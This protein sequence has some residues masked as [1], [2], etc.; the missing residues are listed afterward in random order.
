MAKQAYSS[1]SNITYYYWRPT[2][3]L[4]Q[5]R[6]ISFPNYSSSTPHVHFILLHPRHTQ[7]QKY[8]KGY[9]L[10]SGFELWK[11]NWGVS[12]TAETKGLRG[13]NGMD[14]GIK[15]SIPPVNSNPGWDFLVQW[16]N[17]SIPPFS[18][19]NVLHHNYLPCSNS[20]IHQYSLNTLHVTDLVL[21]LSKKSPI[22]L[23]LVHGCIQQTGVQWTSSWNYVV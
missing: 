19:F 2:Q 5:T 12:N 14:W 23:I 8:S 22:V 15:P 18:P 9:L 16:P 21:V 4:L 10:G 6:Y 7:P 13:H 1:R 20:I 17:T 11:M 3:G